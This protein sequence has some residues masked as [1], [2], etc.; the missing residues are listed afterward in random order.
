[1]NEANIESTQLQLISDPEDQTE[2]L[3]L[4][5][6]EVKIFQKRQNVYPSWL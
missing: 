5:L 4:C 6:V 2:D 3:I 1:M